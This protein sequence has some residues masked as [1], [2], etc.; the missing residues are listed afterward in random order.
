MRQVLTALGVAGVVAAPGF[1]AGAATLGYLVMGVLAAWLGLRAGGGALQAHHRHHEQLER[2]SEELA[3]LNA[4]AM[5]ASRSLDISAVLADCLK[6]TLD[7]LKLDA[8]AVFLLS[9]TGE[10]AL[11][12]NRGLAADFLEGLAQMRSG[13][14]DALAEPEALVLLE[15][16]HRHRGG[17]RVYASVRVPI[18]Y[19]ESV[20]GLM[21][22]VSRTYR[23]FTRREV[24]NL[25]SIGDVIGMAVRNAQLHAQVRERAIRDALTGLYNRRHFEE[26]Y[27][28][29]VERAR[30]YGHPLTVA[31]ID[32]DGF[33]QI[34]DRFG[35]VT[36]DRVLQVVGGILQ[37]GRSSDIVVRY[38]GDEFAIVMPNTDLRGAAVVAERIRR[39]ARAAVIAGVLD[40][41]VAL[42]IG[43]ADSTQGYTRLVERADALMYA[44]KRRGQP[45]LRSGERAVGGQSGGAGE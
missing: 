4:I 41:G 21:Y 24:Q 15:K 34:N 10:S 36:G 16:P 25:A 45:P 39:A 35:H 5:T 12:A 33:K 44:E 8:G 17:D 6:K 42:S 38:G 27:A 30:R 37:E 14:A 32:I 43:L 1:I 29:E 3:V 11:A 28:R 18:R 40:N 22:L 23:A 13:G 19:G 20:L 2:R 9:E 26:A 7:L 31:M